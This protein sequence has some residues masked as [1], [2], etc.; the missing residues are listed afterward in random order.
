MRYKSDDSV[1]KVKTGIWFC[2]TTSR[3]AS[4]HHACLQIWATSP[5]LPPNLHPNAPIL[6]P[7]M[8]HEGR[9]ERYPHHNR[10]RMTNRATS[11]RPF[12]RQQ[13]GIDSE[14][15]AWRLQFN[16][17][18]LLCMGS[19]VTALRFWSANEIFTV[20]SNPAR[21]AHLRC[22]APLTDTV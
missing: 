14:Q 8:Q 6:P 12:I 10:H 4:P 11:R 18:H 16:S 2:Y 9:P 19:K 15:R 3:Q 1:R 17:V 5:L 21:R 13:N 7:E 22:S 20:K